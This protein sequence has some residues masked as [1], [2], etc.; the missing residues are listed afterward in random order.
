MVTYESEEESGLVGLQGGLGV[1]LLFAMIE[2][3]L[4]LD[5][6]SSAQLLD[7]LW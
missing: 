2:S 1:E 6:R 7:Q 3:A 4:S 5:N